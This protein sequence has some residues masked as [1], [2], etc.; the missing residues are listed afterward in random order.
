[1]FLCWKALNFWTCWLSSDSP[2]VSGWELAEVISK[3]PLSHH[4]CLCDHST[5][6]VAKPLMWTAG[7]RNFL[8]CLKA[9]YQ[10]SVFNYQWRYR[11]KLQNKSLWLHL[12]YYF[13]IQLQDRL[14]RYDFSPSSC[15]FLAYRYG[16][17]CSSEDQD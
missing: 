9:G 3:C 15:V 16:K 2:C 8:V 10:H 17:I 7:K 11:K 5:T 12:F 1:M 14:C 6:S 4:L 13:Q